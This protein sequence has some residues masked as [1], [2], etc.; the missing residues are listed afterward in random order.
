MRK[1]VFLLVWISFFCN[2]Q[3]VT[4]NGTYFVEPIKDKKWSN[5]NGENF[6]N[7]SFSNFNGSCY[8]ILEVDETVLVSF[9][10]F[11]KI[12]N[13]TLEI[14]LI[15]ENETNLLYCKTVKQC[16]NSKKITLEKNKKYRLY[17]TGKNAKGN[18]EVNWKI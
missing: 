14:K 12:K 9:H 10:S 1:A 17:F 4:S 11:T 5:S 7:A 16:E 3:Q 15:D 18:Y 13:G 2:A 6:T 8:V